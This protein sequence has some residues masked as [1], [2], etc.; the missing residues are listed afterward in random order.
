MAQPPW[1]VQLVRLDGQKTL[2]AVMIS[3]SADLN[4][5]HPF[6]SNADKSI[7]AIDYTCVISCYNI[8]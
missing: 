7:S 4:S 8:F 1:V 3:K 5:K 6:L 2:R